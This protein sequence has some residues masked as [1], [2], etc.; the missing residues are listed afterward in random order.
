[1][2]RP[3]VLCSND[4]GIDS[5]HLEA[6]AGLIE[7]FAQSGAGGV[8][9]RDRVVV[10]LD[11]TVPKLLDGM[12][13]LYA[14][15]LFERLLHPRSDPLFKLE[16]PSPDDVDARAA[17]D[18]AAHGAGGANLEHARRAF[19]ECPRILETVLRVAETW[20]SCA[21]APEKLKEFYSLAEAAAQELMLLA[22]TLRVAATVFR[23]GSSV[24]L[25][26]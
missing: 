26:I 5:P 14:N 22:T 10:A 25:G 3:L 13:A 20:A 8:E 6:L 15:V 16:V 4:D 1:M 7:A 23:G 9:W 11:D 2:T 17:S 12:Q 18:I 21:K 19:A 24:T